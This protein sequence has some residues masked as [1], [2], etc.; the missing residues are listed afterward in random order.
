MRGNTKRIYGIRVN[1]RLLDAFLSNLPDIRKARTNHQISKEFE[2]RIMLAVTQ[3]NGCSLCS[4]FHT[5][6]AL[7][8]GM[9]KEQIQKILEGEIG[10]VP[11]EETE[12]LIFAQHYADTIGN[13]DEKAWQRIITIYGKDKANAI[14]AY[15]RVI[16]VG[17]AQGNIFGALKT[18]LSGKPESNSTF[19]KEISVILSDIFIIPFLLV[20]AGFLGVLNKIYLRREAGNKV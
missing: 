13:Y 10:S 20:K 8:M 16:M 19:L 6:E 12:A 4:Y 3:V 5:K 1:Y 11:E 2:K 7:R 17:N 15:I 14:L 9:E 18:R